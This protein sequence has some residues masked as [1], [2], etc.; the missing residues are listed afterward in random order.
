MEMMAFLTDNVRIL[1]ILVPF[2]LLSLTLHEFAHARTALAFGDPTAQ[3]AG[4]ITLN[5]LEHLDPLGTIAIIFI[6]FGWAKPVPVNPLNMRNRTI[7]EI[8]V[9]LAGPLTNLGLALFFALV[10]KG[11]QAAGRPVLPMLY[12][13]TGGT[14]ALLVEALFLAMS[15][16]VLLCIF[17]LL[18]LYPLD[19]HHIVRE[20]LPR[21]K[22]SDFMN[23]QVR[24]GMPVMLA[25]IFG[26]RLLST[27]FKVEFFDPL[28]E[29]H[30]SVMAVMIR[31]VLF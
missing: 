31:I 22:Q 4:R 17:N 21:H 5:P 14:E 20:T 2:L 3:Q 18:P 9:S 10:L 28:G 13:S 15:I 1:P 26:P 19:G 24:Y 16:N 8:T 12:S 29:A 23:W 27:I 6:G 25:V 11:M 7:G 30:R